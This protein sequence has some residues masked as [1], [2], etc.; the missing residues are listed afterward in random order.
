[1]LCRGLLQ[2]AHGNFAGAYEHFK[3]LTEL[4][5]S[6]VV[7]SLASVI[8]L[9]LVTVLYITGFKPFCFIL[10]SCFHVPDNNVH[11]YCVTL[12]FVCAQIFTSLWVYGDT[13]TMHAVLE[14][15]PATVNLSI[16]I[17][18]HIHASSTL[19]NPVTLTVD[20]LTS[21]SCHTVYAYQVWC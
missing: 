15:L 5:S 4:D 8:L 9:Y 20:L 16:Y 2:L 17:N 14:Q 13:C 6:N 21:G 7:V 3:N 11:S 12:Y 10:N 18:M 1:V 19:H